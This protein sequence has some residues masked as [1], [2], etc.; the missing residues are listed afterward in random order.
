VTYTSEDFARELLVELQK[1]YDIVRL[2]RWAMTTYLKHSNE[3]EPGL[4]R[5][6]LKIV[7]MEEGPE[8]ELSKDELVQLAHRLTT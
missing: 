5:E 4:D 6:I 8:F 7:A 1:G 3:T 2:S